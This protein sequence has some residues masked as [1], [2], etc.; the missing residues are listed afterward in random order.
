M[1]LFFSDW[2]HFSYTI[3]PERRAEV[4][5]KVYASETDPRILLRKPQL[6]VIKENSS[7]FNS[8][9]IFNFGDRGI[10]TGMD[11]EEKIKTLSEEGRKKSRAIFRFAEKLGIARFGMDLKKNGDYVYENPMDILHCRMGR[12]EAVHLDIL[13]I[14]AINHIQNSLRIKFFQEGSC[15][16]PKETARLIRNGSVEGK[17]RGKERT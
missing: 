9:D 7:V 10:F 5:I 8:C 3:P 15:L 1:Y 6:T 14:G 11:L 13:K 12:D 4:F 17:R 16:T 2:R